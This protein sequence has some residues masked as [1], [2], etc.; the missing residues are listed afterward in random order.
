M[1]VRT[2]PPERRR[3]TVARPDGSTFETTKTIE[4]AP[5]PQPPRDW[6]VI[7]TRAGVGMVL[8]LTAV[9]VAWSTWSIGSLLHGGLGFLAATVFDLSW[10]TCLILEWKARYDPD[11]RAFPRALGWALLVVTMGAIFWHGAPDWR[12]A[13]VGALTSAIAKVLWLGIMKHIERELSQQDRDDLAD[14]LSK[15]HVRQAVALVDRQTLRVDAHTEALRR[16]LEGARPTV[17]ELSASDRDTSPAELASAG[18]QFAEQIANT[19]EPVREHPEPVRE[20][21]ANGASTPP[22]TSP[23]TDRERPNMAAIVREQIAN[24]ASN[25]EAIANVLAIIPEANPG[26]VGA[27]VRR[28]RRKAGPYL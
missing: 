11:K 1:K 26:S 10:A 22:P 5:E 7:S 12:M 3:V 23:N 27:A 25:A 4:F 16:S 8:A 13:T 9:A 14:R 18:R 2:P 6:D 21:I 19:G 28:E 17:L 15:A 24:T 20:Q